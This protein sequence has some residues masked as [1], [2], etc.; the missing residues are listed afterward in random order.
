[1]F[2]LMLYPLLALLGIAILSGPYGCQMIWHKLACL[3]DA[4][5]HGALLGLSFGLIMH[6]P[7]SV[8]LFV[9][10][11][12]WALFLWLLT[13]KKKASTDTILAFLTQSSMALAILLYA[14]GGDTNAPLMHA[15]L[16]DVLLTSKSDVLFIFG[17][18]IVL[19]IILIIGWKKWLLIAINPD[20]A[21]AQKFSVS[22][23]TFLF[24]ASIGF[25]VAQSMQYLG[26]LLAPAFFVMPPLIARPLSNTPGKMAFFSSMVAIL[27]AC[28]GVIISYY[29]DLPTS[30]AIIA[31][32]LSFYCLEFF[33]FFIKKMLTK[34]VYNLA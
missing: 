30:A 27:S 10:S 32:N 31:V 20:L 19:G 14:I 1:M 6:L 25:F 4:L 15:F 12:F 9:L 5:S 26:A 21:A 7:K 3:G 24:F 11:V 29:F 2:D 18:D 23:Y 33:V 8:S 17:L 34:K 28:L 13:Y 22:F 16:G